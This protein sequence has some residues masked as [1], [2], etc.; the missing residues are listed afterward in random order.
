MI[1]K[2]GKTLNKVGING[3]LL[4]IFAAIFATSVAAWLLGYSLIT[5]SLVAIYAMLGDLL[6]S[7][8]KRRLAMAPSSAAPFLDQVPE[9]FFPAFMMMQ[10]FNLE[11]SSVILLVLIFIIMELAISHVLYFWGIR[12]RPY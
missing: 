3:F 8:I 6:S 5:G 10:V 2:L 12:K 7:F 11:I 1:R 4:G 9:S